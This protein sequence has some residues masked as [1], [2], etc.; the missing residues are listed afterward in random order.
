MTADMAEPRQRATLNGCVT[1]NYR[2]IHSSCVRDM[3]LSYFCGLLDIVANLLSIA[4]ATSTLCAFYRSNWPAIG[5]S[6]QILSAAAAGVGGVGQIYSGPSVAGDWSGDGAVG[7]KPVFGVPPTHPRYFRGR[8]A[9]L[10]GE[11]S[12]TALNRVDIGYDAA[13]N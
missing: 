6:R 12:R 10:F 7:G 5:R 2:Y 3:S 8:V 1:V 13:F 4:C 9:A 11:P